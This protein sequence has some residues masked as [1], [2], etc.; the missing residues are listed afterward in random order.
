M[1][2]ESP[3]MSFLAA[4]L[5]VHTADISQLR[6]FTRESLGEMPL[7]QLTKLAAAEGIEPADLEVAL[8]SENRLES[9]KRLLLDLLPPDPV[10]HQGLTESEPELQETAESSVQSDEDGWE[11]VSPSS[12]VRGGSGL[13]VPIDEFE[14][15]RSG[16]S[17]VDKHWAKP[18]LGGTSATCPQPVTPLVLHPGSVDEVSIYA[19]TDDHQHLGRT[20]SSEHPPVTQ[21]KRSGPRRQSVCSW[22]TGSGQAEADA[23]TTARDS[24]HAFVLLAN[25][26]DEE[27][28]GRVLLALMR[29]E[30]D[31]MEILFSYFS[32]LLLDHG[33]PLQLTVQTTGL[34]CMDAISADR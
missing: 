11:M 5:L 29:M 2:G 22:N 23:S 34:T 24:F 15:P 19:A 33:T 32:S 28:N 26:I 7:S 14:S 4:T 17:T 25:I 18:G 13:V 6:G 30:A 9:V 21:K 31:K 1:C 20:G 3:G 8:R 27:K 12:G 10:G 16:S